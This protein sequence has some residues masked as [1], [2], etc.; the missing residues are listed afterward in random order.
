MQAVDKSFAQAGLK[1]FQFVVY[2]R[3]V[4]LGVGVEAIGGTARNA[5]V[6]RAVALGVTS[7]RA[8]CI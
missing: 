4:R 2:S 3:N 7:S 8:P 5:R 1:L 6:Y